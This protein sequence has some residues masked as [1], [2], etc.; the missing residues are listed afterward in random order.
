M[1]CRAYGEDESMW[2]QVRWRR[3][4]SAKLGRKP[5]VRAYDEST[6]RQQH[7]EI[8]CKSKS[9]NEEIDLARNESVWRVVV[10]LLSVESGVAVVHDRGCSSSEEERE[11]RGVDGRGLLSC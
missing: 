9:F 6:L 7:D 8:R 2:W 1:I 3:D 4:D 5:Q 10:E 11:K